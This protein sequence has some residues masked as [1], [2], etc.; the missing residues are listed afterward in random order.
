MYTTLIEISIF[1]APPPHHALTVSSIHL[2]MES[3]ASNHS[4]FDLDR[5]GH[6]PELCSIYD[7]PFPTPEYDV[8]IPLR[9]FST[10]GPDGSMVRVTPDSPKGL[11]ARLRRALGK[12]GNIFRRGDR[13]GQ[14]DEAVRGF[15][16]GG[17][18]GGT[19]AA[20]LLGLPPRRL[21]DLP[22]NISE[23]AFSEQSTLR[24]VSGS[25]E[26]VDTV[27]SAGTTSTGATVSTTVTRRPSRFI[28]IGID[29]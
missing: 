3:P 25:E 4:A 15:G 19:P 17:P 18:A 13:E 23:P 8:G 14:L 20:S 12:L 27:V 11:C 5:G 16:L 24:L 22:A 2:T 10:R 28:E 7:Y 29:H 21:L 1:L 26:S 9:A 6:G